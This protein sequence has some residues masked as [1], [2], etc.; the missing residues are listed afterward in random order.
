MSKGSYWERLTR[1]RLSR[2]RV[3]AG[4]A[5]LGAAAAALSLVG[6][7]GGEEGGGE[8]AAGGAAKVQMP[9]QVL[10][11][12]T[13]DAIPGGVYR[14]A[15]SSNTVTGSLDP[16]IS[17]SS[18]TQSAAGSALE[19]LLTS[20]S[21]PERKDWNKYEVSPRLAES[22]E[23]SSDATTF[24][25]RMRSGVRFHDIPPVNGRVMDIEDWR[26]SLERFL[27]V[28]PFKSNLA[29][30]LDSYS[31]PDSR[32][33]VLKTKYPYAPLLRLFTSG[34]STFWVMPKEAFDGR[35]NPGTTMIGTNYLVRDKYQPDIIT[36]HKRHD[37]YWLQKPWIERWRSFVIPEREQRRAQF[38]VKNLESYTP[39]QG[40]VLQMA[41]DAPDATMWMGDITST[42]FIRTWF[43]LKGFETSPFR[44]ERA[45]QAFAMVSDWP[46][47]RAYW[48]N[49]KEFAAAGLPTMDLRYSFVRIGWMD[50]GY[51]LDPNKK[52]L[53]DA[54]KYLLFNIPEAKKLLEAAGYTS[55]IEIPAAYYSMGTQY[56]NDYLTRVMMGWDLIEQS[57][58]FKVAKR[59]ALPFAEYLQTIYYDQD[60]NGACGG[61]EINATEVDSELYNWYHSKGVRFKAGGIKDPK[62]DD[63]VMRQRSEL[64]DEKRK[65]IIHDFQKYMATKMYTIPYDGES[66]SYYFSWGYLRNTLWPGWNHFLRADYPDRNG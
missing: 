29:E 58:L 19:T 31:F 43:G 62:V 25:F 12:E 3:V 51:W 23:V 15:S 47:L 66:V 61:P 24:T 56:G 46:T 10:K 65:T 27:A 33:M 14:S 30:P 26:L 35:L 55:A 11:D 18:S 50:Y 44:D 22:W 54:S 42:G 17:T 8:E 2:R 39:V 28:S 32:T 48:S 20:K 16:M 38:L 6:C 37:N 60:F 41:K 64:D 59:I 4:A 13:K 52:E 40:D 53:G 45:R 21:R 63:F 36:E 49:S 5:G 9:Y 57:G 1:R 7:G 34:S